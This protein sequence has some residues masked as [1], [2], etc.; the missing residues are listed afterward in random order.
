MPD[1]AKAARDDA[2]SASA[3][4]SSSSHSALDAALGAVRFAAIAPIFAASFQ[5]SLFCNPRDALRLDQRARLSTSY[6]WARFMTRTV[7]NVR[8][9]LA[10]GSR[11]LCRER[12]VVYLCNHR[13]WS[14]F[15]VDV[16][17]TEGRAFTMSRMLVAYAFPLFMA[18]AMFV[19]AVFG[20][21]R[22]GVRDKEQLNR[23]LDAHF[24][25]FHDSYGGVVI[26]PEGTRNIRDYSLPLKRGMLRYAHTRRMSVQV[27]CTAGKERVFSSHLVSAERDC[28]LPIYFS[29]AIHAEEYPDFEDFYN[30]VR[31]RWD[32]AWEGANVVRER[33]LESLPDY[34]PKELLVKA[35]T[36]ADIVAATGAILTVASL[37]F[38]YMAFTRFVYY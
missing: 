37:A 19:G 31:A 24:E 1:G 6:V 12:K 21:N 29:D 36:R 34:A 23:D 18:P 14:D 17:S 2:G 38:T 7:M 30:E 33:D 5:L 10:P 15:F 11:E 22:D 16:Y 3:S 8:L 25:T 28:V 26:Y 27:I 4:H 13:A 35:S 32:D 20:F 9:K